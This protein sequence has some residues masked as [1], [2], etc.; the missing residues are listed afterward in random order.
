MELHDVEAGFSDDGSHFL[1]RGVHEHTDPPDPRR[2]RAGDAARLF[3][4]HRPWTLRPEHEADGVDAE[5]GGR[6]RVL[7]PR[8]AAELDA[9][10]H[11]GAPISASS[12]W[13]GC[14]CV[15]SRSPIKHAW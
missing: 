13:P 8:H 11:A 6:D 14:G 2:Q 1:D 4:A 5:I 10:D 3:D 12:A 15:T 9:R 7:A